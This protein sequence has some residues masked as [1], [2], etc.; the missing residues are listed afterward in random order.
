MRNEMTVQVAHQCIGRRGSKQQA[1]HCQKEQCGE[2][3]IRISVLSSKT[4]L[5]RAGAQDYQKGFDEKS[6]R[7]CG[8]EE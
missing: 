2:W 8:L 4:G 7:K 1:H 5:H 3:E 6:G